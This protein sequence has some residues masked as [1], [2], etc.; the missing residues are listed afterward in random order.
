MSTVD[1]AAGL[2]KHLK[3]EEWHT[4]RGLEKCMIGGRS[5]NFDAIARMSGQP[6]ERTRFALDELNKR[7]LVGFAGE[8]Y[9]VY[10][11]ALDL[12]ALKHYADKDYAMALG[13]LIAKGKES[14]VYEV[15]SPKSE[16]FALKLFRLGRTSFRDVKR[17]RSR[18]KDDS[19]TWVTSNY[20]AARHEFAALARLRKLTENVPTAVDQDRHTVLLQELPGVRLA[21]RPELDD[22]EEILSMIL[23]TAREAYTVSKMINGDL[24]EYNILTDGRRVWLID[25]PQWVGPT[26]PNAAELLKRDVFTVLRFFVRAYGVKVDDD[27][28]LRYVRGEVESLKVRRGRSSTRVSG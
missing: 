7:K 20:N 18:S 16:L 12:L 15:L 10:T 13:K 22:A 21:Q 27:R 19:N 11:S 25:W 24:S 4:L 23:Q 28:A 9:V 6:A 1:V 2:I 17:K 5:T 8:N 26:H 14:D 3:D